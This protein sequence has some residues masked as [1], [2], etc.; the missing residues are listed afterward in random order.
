VSRFSKAAILG[1]ATGVAGLVAGV[2]PFWIAFGENLDLDLLFRLRG[3]RAPPDEVLVVSVD[4]ASADRFGLPNDL[5]KWPR[6]LHAD[7]IGRLSAGGASVIAFD[8]FFEEPRPGDEDRLFA[9]A[10]GRARNVILCQRMQGGTV[11]LTDKEGAPAPGLSIAKT[12]PPIRPL[13]QAAAALAPFPLPKIP[14]KVN[15]GW[16]FR[17]GAGE[18]PTMPIVA[19][20][21]FAMPV[22]GEFRDLLERART[23]L[24]ADPARESRNIP[25]AGGVE[26]VVRET[27]NIFESDPAIGERML[28]EIRRSPAVPAD[29][30]RRR[31]I[32]SLV[33]MYQ[34]DV[35]RCLNFYG[36]PRTVRTIPYYRFIEKD[37]G[38]S[39]K[40][41]IDV[42]GKAVFVGSSESWQPEQKDG[43]YTVFSRGD[44]LDL[45]GVEIAATAFGNLLEDLP[46]RP[47]DDRG[48]IAVVFL[49][50]LAIGAFCR[51]FPPH[52]AALGAAGAC[53][54]Y[55]AAAGRQFAAD[56][57]WY[58]IT[59]PLFLQA[60]LALGATV[61]WNYVDSN[62][63]RRN[64]R[65]AFEHYL[66][67]D[68]VDRLA[69]NI[70][71][72]KT[73]NQVVY[74]ICLATDAE[75]YTSLSESMGPKELGSFMNRYYEAVFDPVNRH[76][77]VVSNVIGDS[78]LAIWVDSRSDPAL[79][80]RSCLAALDIAGAM[81]RIDPSS[82]PA[83]LQTRIGLHAGH[84]MLGNIGAAGHYEYRPVGDIVNTATRIEGLNKHLGTRILASEEV[85]RH[86]DNFLTREVG[87]FL[88]AGKSKPVVVHE[89]VCRLSD[90][91]GPQRIACR[92]F[93]EALEAFRGRRWEEAEKI[94]LE[95]ADSLGAD[96]PSRFHVD[97]CALYHK[98]PPGGSWDGAVR[99]DKK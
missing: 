12:V 40:E 98:H 82:C 88:L 51:L 75:H 18:T 7:L 50:G 44:G 84:I 34:S 29:P 6:S 2:L 66:P 99:M 30:A 97:L 68:V 90:S 57:T 35:S 5:R 87:K 80:D 49:W 91:A 55:L 77:G 4:K 72:L 60:P 86:L 9:D 76:G 23:D 24:P 62:R 28:E 17:T 41:T 16:T 26:S 95:V 13:S 48:R 56:G 94:F 38:S 32:A 39:G 25:V 54:L 85:A 93:E 36:P 59:I 47:L 92:R 19:F 52:I 22:Y 33:R 89:L 21:V 78:M 65:R 96:G 70:S 27:R 63:E 37:G 8:I 1:L 15:R 42:S 58:P 20:Q 83:P 14:F 71:D 64:I 81:R 11:S 43:F 31:L 79:K 61:L 45:S 69:K 10:M 53:I 67:N 74:G 3:Q 73:G 46:V